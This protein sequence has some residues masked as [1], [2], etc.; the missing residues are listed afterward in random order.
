MNF[1]FSPRKACLTQF[2]ISMFQGN[3]GLSLG[4][5][6][7]EMP[8]GSK[9][10]FQPLFLSRILGVPEFHHFWRRRGQGMRQTDAKTSS[11]AKD[12]GHI[13]YRSYRSERLIDNDENLGDCHLGSPA[14]SARFGWIISGSGLILMGVHGPILVASTTAICLP[15]SALLNVPPLNLEDA[16]R[17]T[18]IGIPE[19]LGLR[20]KYRPHHGNP[21]SD[22][23]NIH[24]R[25]QT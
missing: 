19:R 22:I 23:R 11:T 25:P 18:G 21:T 6:C 9:A 20:R 2:S 3:R 8:A 15:L 5:G 13:G 14:S 12:L 7:P 24:P 17:R 1:D 10:S 16:I 4:R